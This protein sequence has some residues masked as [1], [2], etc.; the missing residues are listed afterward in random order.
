MKPGPLKIGD[1]LVQWMVYK[2]QMRKINDFKVER[3][4]RKKNCFA[5]QRIPTHKKSEISSHCICLRLATFW[6]F[7]CKHIHSKTDRS[8][9][10]LI[11][12]FWFRGAKHFK[13]DVTRCSRSTGWAAS[14]NEMRTHAFI[15]CRNALHSLA[16]TPLLNRRYHKNFLFCCL[17]ANDGLLLRAL[18]H[19]LM[20]RTPVIHLPNWFFGSARASD[21]GKWW[22]TEQTSAI[23]TRRLFHR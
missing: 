21:F 23:F 19:N 8:E 11:S 10:R 22:W 7:E 12:T 17:F 5:F 15:S 18:L 14:Q 4:R 2:K 20:S 1:L 6:L 13:R 3:S 9:T 16:G